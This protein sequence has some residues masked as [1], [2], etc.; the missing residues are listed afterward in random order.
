MI[1]PIVHLLALHSLH[2]A[3]PALQ[4]SDTLWQQPSQ[5]ASWQGVASAEIV[6]RRPA[7]Q[8]PG[9]YLGQVTHLVAMRNGGVLLI[10]EQPEA[11][12][13][14]ILD[15]QGRYDHGI[16]RLGEGPGE[17]RF[18][19]RAAVGPQG[20]IFVLSQGLRRISKWSEDGDLMLEVPTRDVQG[21]PHLFGLDVSGAGA[22]FV[23]GWAYDARTSG[24]RNSLWTYPPTRFQKFDL[25]TGTS[26]APSSEAV[27]PPP[28]NRVPFG[29]AFFRV[30]LSDGRVATVSSDR[31]GFTWRD[32]TGAVKGV[33]RDYPRFPVSEEERKEQLAARRYM[34]DNAPAFFRPPDV[35]IPAYKQR[36]M[37]ARS[38]P[39]GY[40]WLRLSGRGTRGRPRSGGTITGGPAAPSLTFVEPQRYAV[41]RNDGRFMG[42]VEFPL[43][44]EDLSFHG[45]WAWG[46]ET[47]DFGEQTLVKFRTPLPLP[48]RAGRS[49]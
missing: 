35:T 9:P 22:L 13:I 42:E 32:P 47:S 37:G 45:A 2:G 44:V 16:G 4:A 36:V 7:D 11:S 10:D 26:S 17:M 20:Q 19:V 38:D 15:P 21:S 6:L 41:F 28:T 23:V 46:V 29:P 18:P 8:S 27:L 24:P 39:A 43:S 33:W 5:A 3:H 25:Q 34:E 30:L 14:V 31:V 49:P 40:L 48:R 12:P 1:A